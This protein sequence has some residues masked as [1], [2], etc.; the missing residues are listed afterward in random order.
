MPLDSVL[1]EIHKSVVDALTKAV[2]DLHFAATFPNVTAERAAL[3][4]ARAEMM[5]E[6]A[7]NLR[8]LLREKD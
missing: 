1:H 4:R 5:H 7:E 6:H 3:Y 2:I 8:A